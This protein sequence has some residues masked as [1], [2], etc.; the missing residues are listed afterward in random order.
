MSDTP[1]VP[2][3]L[4]PLPTVSPAS[5]RSLR[6]LLRHWVR[7]PGRLL[8]IGMLVSLIGLGSAVAGLYVRAYFHFRSGRADLDR[9]HNAQALAHFQAYLCTWPNN[10]DALFLSARA[11]WRLQ[12]FDD[13]ERYLKEYQQAA[14]TTEDYVRESAFVMAARGQVDEATEYCQDLL[15]RR[16]PATPLILEAAVTGYLRQY[17]LAEAAVLLLSWLKLQPDDTQA[18]FLQGD[19]DFMRFA[20]EEAITR[21]RRILELDPEHDSARFQLA[22]TLVEQR[23]YQEAL[24]HLEM[25]RQRQPDNKRAMVFLARCRDSLGQSEAAEQLLDQVLAQAPH[26]AGALAARGRLALRRGQL[27][28]AEAWLRHALHHEPADYQARY[29]LLQCLLQEGKKAKAREQE[30]RLKQMDKDQKRIREIVTQE[31][32]EKPHDPALL[33]ELA[34]I[35]LRSG[36]TEEGIRWLHNALRENPRSVPLHRALAEYYHQIGNTPRAAYHRQFVPPQ[37][38]EPA[39]KGS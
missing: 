4:P 24:S 13:A 14:G 1:V 31:M 36:D 35:F 38:A 16:D 20:H 22:V 39:H 3:A 8:T 9:H 25:L 12:K 29:H 19:L 17:R 10:P 27:A 2:V 18:L 33:D 26:H 28:D 15:N 23:Q 32:S 7:R 34:T 30:Q 5:G 6:G 11:S 21:Y 37:S